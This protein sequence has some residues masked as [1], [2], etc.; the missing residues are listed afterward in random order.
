MGVLA[1]YASAQ[2]HVVLDRALYLPQEWT[3]D[4]ARCEGAGIPAER[5]F[6]TKPQ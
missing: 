2:G 5:L 4:T 3:N 1:T 6:A